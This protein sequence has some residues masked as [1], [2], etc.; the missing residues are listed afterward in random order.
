MHHNF[1]MARLLILSDNK[2]RQMTGAVRGADTG[3]DRDIEERQRVGMKLI[4]NLNAESS[5]CQGGSKRPLSL[6]F[7]IESSLNAGV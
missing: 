7:A 6:V 3:I 2:N 5:I 1:F 4:S